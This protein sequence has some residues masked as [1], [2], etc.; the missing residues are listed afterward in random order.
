MLFDLTAKQ[1]L[2]AKS[3]HGD[4]RIDTEGDTRAR[5]TKILKRFLLKVPCVPVSRH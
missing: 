3:R 2:L 4:R 5:A 1:L